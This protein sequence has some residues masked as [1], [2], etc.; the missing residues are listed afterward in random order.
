MKKILFLTSTPTIAVNTNPE[1]TGLQ[2]FER[3]TDE[4]YARLSAGNRE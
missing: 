2:W 3:I 4:E 1:L